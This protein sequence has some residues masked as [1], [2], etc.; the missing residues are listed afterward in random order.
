MARLDL[1][2]NRGPR[3]PQALL[4]RRDLKEVKVLLDILPDLAPKVLLA[5]RVLLGPKGPLEH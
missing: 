5:S 2:A 4:V 3:V 1:K